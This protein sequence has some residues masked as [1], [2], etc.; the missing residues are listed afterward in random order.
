[1]ISSSAAFT[2]DL[3]GWNELLP[4]RPP[5][6][7]LAGAHR[8]PWV[9]IGAGVTG[10]A[11]ARRLAERHPDDPVLLLEAREIGQGASGRNSG[12]AVATSHFP[13]ELDPA[14]IANAQRVNRINLDG[15]N[16]LQQLVDEHAIDCHWR[17]R[18]FFHTAA[19]DAALGEYENFRRYLETL[20]VEHDTHDRAAT[21]ERLGTEYF[22]A[23]V[24]VA[25]GALVQPALLVR[26][27]AETLQANVVLHERSPV[28]EVIPG[29]PVT[30]RL[31]GAEVQADQ[32][33]LAVNY[34]AGRL[35]YLRAYL[36]GSTLSGSFT[37]RLTR[38]ELDSLGKLDQWG[39]L[40]LHGGGATLR[41][42][43]DGRISIRN[44][45]EYHA[46]TLLSDAE[47][48]RRQLVHRESFERRFPQLAHVPFE[49][50]WSGVEGISRNATNFF[51]RQTKNIF[52]AGGYNGSGLSR[53]TAFGT[54]IADYASGEST[55]T[56][57]DCLESVAAAWM[58]PR[59]LL[60]IAAFFTVRARF[61]GVGADR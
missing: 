61:R 8:V 39:A 50:A 3:H 34:E 1:M 15:L 45:A 54:A 38:A 30:L 32:V 57:N 56:V 52:L 10:L 4:S 44:T 42:S 18:G 25:D 59:P 48:A 55:Q 24:E 6:P 36:T 12:F 47:L 26:A 9:V 49:Y 41:L 23:A 21:A 28:L 33:V 17:R 20:S 31:D 37:R 2:T 11:C 60:D 16:R 27:L 22:R 46:S 5:R 7:P 19:G 13:G 43:R 51:G 35:G 40:S 14:K 53:G 29:S 58:P